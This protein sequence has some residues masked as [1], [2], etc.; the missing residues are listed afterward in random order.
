MKANLLLAVV[1]ALL[2]MSLTSEATVI[3]YKGTGRILRGNN[4]T[5]KPVATTL[6]FVVDFNTLEGRWVF[7]QTVNGVK[8]VFDDGPRF[9]GIAD[10]NTAPNRTV[11][12][13]TT[14][15]AYTN[16]ATFNFFSVR[17]AGKKANVFLTAGAALPAT[18]GK[19]MAGSYSFN[20]GTN[21][22]V[23]DG[24]V[25]VAVDL[26]RTQFSNGNSLAVAA[27]AGAI[28]NEYIGKGYANTVPVP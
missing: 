24:P 19:S 23:V 21:D 13:S 17:L 9:Y 7:A 4:L 3:V 2:G 15:F 18:I 12:Y 5:A 10:V 27:A 20:D 11:T 25:A 22:H 1:A 26:K 14:S 16:A 28:V 8:S 6:F